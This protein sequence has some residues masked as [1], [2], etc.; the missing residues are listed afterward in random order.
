MRFGKLLFL[1]IAAGLL[2]GCPVTQRQDTPVAAR[3]LSDPA[4]G[5]KYWLY[6]PSNYDDQSSWPLVI[7]L[8]GSKVWDGSK[9]QMKE[10]KYL[11]QKQGFL[12]A[13]PKVR[14][15]EGI[16]PTIG[17]AG[18]LAHDENVVLSVIDRIVA[19][20]PAVDPDAVL[21]TGFSA[22]GYPMYYIGLRNPERFDMMIARACNSSMKIF[23]NIEI[24]DQVRS[25]PIA[26]F[27]GKDDLSLIQNQSWQAFR[28]L[29]ENRCFKT[30][31]QMLA[32]GHLRRPGKAY[33]L[34]AQ[35]RQNRGKPLPRPQ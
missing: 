32:G 22:G 31:R 23:E 18:Q 29:R 14:S 25:L 26:I 7:T 5:A 19:D 16:L 20:Y 1:L 21:L 28:W 15:A 2:A 10:W 27:W 12:V 11:A 30:T 13:A 6:V 3:R 33:N 34:W 4:S 17:W 9:R 35:S 24:T 8:H